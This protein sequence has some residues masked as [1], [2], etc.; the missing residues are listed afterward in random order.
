MLLS[1][2][3]SQDESDHVLGVGLTRADSLP[4]F[5]SLELSEREPILTPPPTP[6]D[7]RLRIR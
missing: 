6:I 4:V 5:V 1:S 3:D 7:A 2:Q